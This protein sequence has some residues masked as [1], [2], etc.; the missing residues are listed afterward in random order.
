[1]VGTNL[2]HE[3]VDLAELVKVE[4]GDAGGD[5]RFGFDLSESEDECRLTSGM[6][7]G[8]DGDEILE[9]VGCLTFDGAE[10]RVAELAFSSG[11]AAGGRTFLDVP[12]EQE[13]G[14]GVLFELETEGGQEVLQ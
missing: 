2:L 14:D 9:G 5:R 12:K 7:F 4:L 1:V 3:A 11:N 8:D 6:G 10:Y 13:A